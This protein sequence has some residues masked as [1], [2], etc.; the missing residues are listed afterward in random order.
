[1]EKEFYPKI[2]KFDKDTIYRIHIPKP[3]PDGLYQELF[4]KGIIPKKDLIKGKYYWGKCRNA[5]VAMWNGDNFTHMRTKFNWRY[6]E[7]INHIEDDDGFDLFIPLY[8]TTPTEYETI[9]DGH[10]LKK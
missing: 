1:M 4:Q 10:T 3:I 8:E 6:P 9:K 7:D 5:N 2:E